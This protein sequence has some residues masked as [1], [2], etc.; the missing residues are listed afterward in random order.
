MCQYS[1]RPARSVA[2]TCSYGHASGRTDIPYS[3]AG[4]KQR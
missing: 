1:V 4:Y 3:G 2:A